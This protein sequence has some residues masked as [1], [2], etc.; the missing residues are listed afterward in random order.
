MTSIAL[1]FPHTRL[2]AAL[3]PLTLIFRLALLRPLADAS[4][5]SLPDCP[6]QA[7]DPPPLGDNLPRFMSLVAD[8]TA[9][10]AAEGMSRLL[11]E[12]KVQRRFD[13][14]ENSR[15]LAVSI[16]AAHN[17]E[18]NKTGAPP[19]VLL[20]DERLL[21]TL[22]EFLDDQ[23]IGMNNK[24]Q[25]LDDH[26]RQMLA[27]LHGDGDPAL[28]P[29]PIM[30]SDWQV[31]PPLTQ[32]LT[33]R[34]KAWSR[35]YFASS[36]KPIAPIAIWACLQEVA[37]ELFEMRAAGS[38]LSGGQ[39]PLKLGEIALPS[40][41]DGNGGDGQERAGLSEMAERLAEVLD[42]DNPAQDDFQAF[43]DAWRQKLDQYFPTTSH[44]GTSHGR[45]DFYD[46]GNLPAGKVLGGQGQLA[47]SGRFLVVWQ[48]AG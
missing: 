45:L 22:A 38:G 32:H 30:D 48:A 41:L 6:C 19:D 10:G 4:G 17:T 5:C 28:P 36:D 24:W 39:A 26:Y 9:K 1:I 16:M 31:K 11:L 40:R 46:L 18:G 8:I 42:I 21:L 27:G 15:R 35:L 2:I 13:D 23:E 14:D 34:L 33:A 44:A 47:A 20:W 12:S 7:I 29:D 43:S 3:T 25:Q 37:E